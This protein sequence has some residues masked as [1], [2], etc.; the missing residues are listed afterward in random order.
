MV[1]ECNKSLAKK[2]PLKYRISNLESQ[3]RR[4]KQSEIEMEEKTGK[5]TKK[6][7]KLKNIKENFEERKNLKSS[8]ENLSLDN[9]PL[10][11]S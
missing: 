10:K 6:R 7:I 9:I 4:N 11:T 2:Q 1:S 3:K 5:Q 8:K